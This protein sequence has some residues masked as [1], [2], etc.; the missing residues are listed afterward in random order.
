MLIMFRVKNFTSF[1]DDVVLDLR[2][3]QYREHLNHTFQSGDFELLKTVAIY[4]ANASGK[5]NL[6]SALSYFERFI[7]N[8]LFDEK[9]GFDSE[10]DSDSEIRKT[11]SKPFLLAEP[12][13]KEMEFEIIFSHNNN[14]YQYG[15]CIEETIICSEWLLINNETVFEREKENNNITF[16]KKYEKALKEYNRLREDRL[17]LAILDYFVTDKKIKSKI[18]DF[19]EYFQKKFNIYFELIFE[20]SVKGNPSIISY[21]K[22]FLKN[23]N[24][25]KKI[26]EYIRKIDVGI[27]DIVIDEEIKTDKRTGEQV[28]NL[29]P[30]TIHNIYDLNGEVIGERAFDL[31]LES[32]GTLR[33]LSYIQEILRM[34]EMGGIFIIDELSSRL[35]PLLTKFIVDIFQSEINVSNAQLIFTTHDVSLMNRDQFRRDEVVII[36]KN[37]MGISTLQSL[38]DLGVRQDA[39]FSKDYFNGKYGG[40][41]I[42]DYYINPDNG[43]RNG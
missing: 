9:K 33:F 25:R 7:Q 12:L 1:K 6:I 8:Q 23:E 22:E 5:S 29:L 19:K 36:D 38:A 27:K 11:P 14:V 21:S 13:A 20:S 3:T 15:Y 24:F 26:S 10:T 32:S 37:Q 34:I 30:R 31:K 40:I 4:G 2:K 18:N 41:P 17:Y 39:S 35:H 42:F 16:G 43:D 28:R